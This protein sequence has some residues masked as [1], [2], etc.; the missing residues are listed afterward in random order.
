MQSGINTMYN[1]GGSS[2]G[3]GKQIAWLIAAAVTDVVRLFRCALT[4]RGG[5]DGL[6]PRSLGRLLA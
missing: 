6:V 4:R 2:R 3:A 5:T 1:I